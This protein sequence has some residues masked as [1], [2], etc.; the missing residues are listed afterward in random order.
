M[1]RN[2]INGRALK[3]FQG[4]HTLSMISMKTFASSSDNS[5]MVLRSSSDKKD[6]NKSVNWSDFGLSDRRQCNPGG[7]VFEKPGL[8]KRETTVK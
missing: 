1:F 6:R 5:K 7:A 4:E 8:H 2:K 3:N